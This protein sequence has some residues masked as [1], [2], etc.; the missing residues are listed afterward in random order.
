MKEVNATE[1]LPHQ[2]FDTVRGQTRSR[3]SLQ[4][5][6]QILKQVQRYRS[7]DNLGTKA[8]PDG[9]A[10]IHPHPA[11]LVHVLKDEIENHLSISRVPLAVADVNQAHYVGVA[12]FTWCGNEENIDGQQMHNSEFGSFFT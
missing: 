8:G 11:H 5:H 6:R 10:W 3:A 7:P 1:Q 9:W 4:V 2:V 12:V